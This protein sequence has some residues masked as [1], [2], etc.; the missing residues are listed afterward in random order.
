MTNQIGIMS[1]RLSASFNKKI[2]S[3]PINTWKSEFE[4][5]SSCGFEVIEWVFDS[6]EKNPILDDDGIKEI[7]F[8]SEENQ[9][10][11]KSVCADFFMDNHLFNVSEFNLERNLQILTNLIIN[12]QKL[13]IKILEIPFLE[14]SSINNQNYQNQVISNLQKILPLAHDNDVKLT[15]ETDL[16]PKSFRDLLLHFNHE[17]I[18]ANYDIGNSTSNGFEIKIEL[19]ILFPWIANIHIKDRLLHGRTVP[20]GTGDVN[21]ESFFS[22]ISKLNYNEDF[23]I[24]GA[25]ED[26]E[27]TE[28]DPKTTCEKYLKFVMKYTNKYLN[29][30]NGN[31]VQ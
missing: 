31:N 27:N 10:Q 22:I 23:I 20:L 5:A 19:E 8:L 4:K 6:I 7:K 11:V 3:F 18:A 1:G 25:R 16:N 15:L 9:I 26:L 28:I 21:F 12:C 24:Q 30:I 2:Q 14:S 13:D 17:N 29:E